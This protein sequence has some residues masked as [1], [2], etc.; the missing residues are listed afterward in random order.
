[1]LQYLLKLLKAIFIIYPQCAKHSHPWKTGVCFF[2]FYFEGAGAR[3][4]I[5]FLEIPT[6]MANIFPVALCL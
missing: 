2:P 3:T 4:G 6:G 5:F 1:M